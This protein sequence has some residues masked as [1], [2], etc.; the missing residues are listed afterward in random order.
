MSFFDK[1]T[2]A[3][4]KETS[5]ADAD[6]QA[7]VELI[8]GGGDPDVGHVNTVIKAAGKAPENLRL[9]VELYKRRAELRAKAA[10][11]PQAIRERLSIEQQIERADHE[12]EAAERKRDDITGPLFGRRNEL[13]FVIDEA[14][15]SADELVRSCPDKSLQAELEA[16]GREEWQVKA[17]ETS[18]RN[19]V[20][21]ALNGSKEW[22]AMAEREGRRAEKEA[23]T[24][25]AKR[26]A[27]DAQ[28][29]QQQLKE[30]ERKL[31][32]I[33]KRRADVRARMQQA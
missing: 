12:L 33:P 22:T 6:Y 29:A 11:R 26:C 20:R 8:A 16:L 14:D 25:N 32:V 24:E 17:D 13:D 7:V 27:A 28:E 9:D 21:Q 18:A 10:M 1:F 3:Q 31:S 5:K 15:R 30:I 4:T 23:F 2:E 19:R